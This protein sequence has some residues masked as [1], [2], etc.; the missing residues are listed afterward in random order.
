MKK[1]IAVTLAA[2]M[3][4]AAFAGCAPADPATGGDPGD[5]GGIS[6]EITVISREEGSGTRGAFVELFGI[7]GENE[8]GET[9][10]MTIAT[11]DMTNS[12]GVML[13][14]VSQNTSAIGYVSLGSLDETMVKALEIDGAKASVDAINDGSYKVSR[15]FNIATK[16]DASDAAK[17]FISFILSDDGQKV[18]SENGYI[19]VSEGAY[20]KTGASGSIVVAGSSSVSPVME[21]L[22]EAY[23]AVNSDVSVQLQTSDSTTGMNS[24]IEGVCDI[25]MASRELKDSEIEAGLTPV[26]IA[27]DGIAVIVHPDNPISGL[28]SEQ[29]KGIYTGEITDWSQVQ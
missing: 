28:T 15:P 24:T 29:V 22:I 4:I 2:V 13:Q 14:S 12:T 6:G 17:D 3:T 25:G 5:D 20:E 9:V 23:A 1:I 11:A 10:D 16:A 21:K 19:P 7:E 27:T 26:V 18:V 8:A